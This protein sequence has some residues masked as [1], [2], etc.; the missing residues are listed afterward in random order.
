MAEV[1]R[2]HESNELE[3]FFQARARVWQDEYRAEGRSAGLE[4]GLAA[5]CDLLRHLAA[6]KFGTATAERLAQGLADVADHQ[7]L[8]EAGDWISTARP[9]KN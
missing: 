9:A 3:A 1:D 4:Q 5:E 7:I 6:R 8:Q 2:L